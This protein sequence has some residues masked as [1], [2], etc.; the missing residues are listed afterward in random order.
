MR[1]L[2]VLLR[3]HLS[4]LDDL[5]DGEEPD[6]RVHERAWGGDVLK[7]AVEDDQ[8]ATFKLPD[9]LRSSAGMPVGQ[10]LE[11][12]IKVSIP[13]SERLGQCRSQRGNC[14]LK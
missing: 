4:R 12:G 10:L 11:V 7:R 3:W 5:L 14:L 6:Q 8:V 1:V 9:P 13:S 2:V